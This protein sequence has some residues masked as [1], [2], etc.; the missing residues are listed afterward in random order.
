MSN[1]DIT[2]YG[3]HIKE[4]E[5]KTMVHDRNRKERIV[6]NGNR[7]KILLCTIDKKNY[8]FQEIMWILVVFLQE[9]D[10]HVNIFNS[11]NRS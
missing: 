2:N 5:I 1:N 7:K 9:S 3:S 11:N 6:H 10:F 8:F 4:I